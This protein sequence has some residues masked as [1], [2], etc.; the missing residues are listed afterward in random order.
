MSKRKV[1]VTGLGIVSPVGISLA[2]A[3]GNILNG[4]SGVGPI[5]TFDASAGGLGGCPYAPGAA[6]NLATA[7]LISMLDG[8]EIETGL[9]LSALPG[10]STFIPHLPHPPL[11]A[12]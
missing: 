5:T 4:V 1:V 10:A 9:E 6:G 7:A 3:W 12:L 2:S 8:W 11:P